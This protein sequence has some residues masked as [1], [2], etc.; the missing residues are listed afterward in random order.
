MGNKKDE[1]L[2]QALITPPQ[3]TLGKEKSVVN[4]S[5]DPLETEMEGFV[6]L[7]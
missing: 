1:E 4:L 2:K 5:P 6:T 3:Q 7:R